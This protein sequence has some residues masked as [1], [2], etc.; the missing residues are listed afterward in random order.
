M[1]YLV[2]V[3]VPGCLAGVGNVPRDVQTLLQAAHFFQEL[4]SSGQD[5]VDSTVSGDRRADGGKGLKNRS[6]ANDVC[7]ILLVQF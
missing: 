3:E 7:K 2:E 4:Q 5:V 1:S 6:T